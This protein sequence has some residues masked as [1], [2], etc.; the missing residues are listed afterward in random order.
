MSGERIGA[1]VLAAGRGERLG[2]GVPKALVALAGV[3]LLEHSIAQLSAVDQIERI[4]P[5]VP[6]G[7]LGQLE[8]LAEV[9]RVTSP[10]AGGAERQ[11]SVA[12]GLAELGESFGWVVVHDA[13]RCLVAPRDIA[14]TIEAARA[15]G[16]AGAAILAAPAIDTIKLVERGAVR[17]TLE[18]S[19]CWA[20]QTPQ[21]FRM[22]L[23]RE[24]HA[25]A[26]AEGYVGTDDA[27]LV[28]RLGVEVRV[29]ETS[30]LNLKI[31]TPADLVVAEWWLGQAT[32]RTP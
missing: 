9:D 28:E 31:T 7:V 30:S 26:R 11:D 2:A 13:A 14:R 23:L 25:K 6:S 17:S 18:R 1:L 20:A 27:S 12:A 22:E 3:S 21:V 16:T 8:G 24:A 10:V 5:V 15:T 29:V 4:V 19:A 32:E